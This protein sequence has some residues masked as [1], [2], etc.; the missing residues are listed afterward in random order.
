LI[1][2]TAAGSFILVS[3]LVLGDPPSMIL[4]FA[5]VVVTMSL[6][7]AIEPNSSAL[8]LEP[9][10]NMAGIA[11]SIY[12]TLFFSIGSTLGSIISHLMVDGVY[13]LVIGFFVAGIIS[14]FLL[15]Q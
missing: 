11:A 15:E 4:F 9:M 5:G 12:G 7:L 1:G 13:P 8:A 10:G 2:Y 6:N 14:L 3:T